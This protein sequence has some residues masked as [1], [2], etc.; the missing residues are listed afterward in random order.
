MGSLHRLKSAA[1]FV[2]GVLIGLSIVT[3]V[4]AATSP[5]LEDWN[6]PLGIVALVLLGI[7]MLIN[8]AALGDAR[9]RDM[10]AQ[11]V[12]AVDQDPRAP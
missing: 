3:P 6:G 2:S 7:G 8:A 10:Q 9:R 1:T 5:S 4:F 11:R 12:A